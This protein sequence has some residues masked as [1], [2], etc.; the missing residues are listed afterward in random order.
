M[1]SYSSI[2]KDGPLYP[3]LTLGME[4]ESLKAGTDAVTD[5]IVEA[6]ESY[7]VKNGSSRFWAAKCRKRM[8]YTYSF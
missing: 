2:L 7:K 5:A 8:E 6:Y 3:S 4:F 1:T